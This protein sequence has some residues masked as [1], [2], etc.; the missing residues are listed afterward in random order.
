MAVL[1]VGHM[2]VGG[3]CWTLC[4]L[5]VCILDICPLVVYGGHA[6][7][8]VRVP[9]RGKDGRGS[10]L[11]GRRGVGVGCLNLVLL[12]CNLRAK[13]KAVYAWAS[14]GENA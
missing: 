3:V 9:D 1:Y 11:L 6:V 7:G 12:F 10:E 13:G 8:N 4:L 5:V 2:F 14:R